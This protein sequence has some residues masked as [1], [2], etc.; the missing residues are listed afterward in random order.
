MESSRRAVESYWRWRLIDSATSDEDKVTPVYKLEEICELL[1]SSHPNIVKELSEFILKRFDNKSPIVKHKA[2]RLIKYAV[3]KCGAEFRRE[4]QRHSVAIR[5]LLHYKGQLDPMKG[6]A[7]NK[8]VRDT[9]QEAIAAIFSSDENNKPPSSAPAAADLNRRIQGFGNTNFQAPPQGKKSFLSEVV[10]LGSATI[11]Q[12]LSAFTQGHSSL[13]KNEAGTGNY[14]GPN[15][16]SSFN[17]E[18][19]QRGDRYEPVAYRRETQ[20]ASGLSRNQSGGPWN[21]DTGP[22]RIEISNGK[23]DASYVESKTREDRLMETVASSGGVRLQPTREAIQVFLTEA[24]KLDAMALCHAIERKLQSPMW[25]VRVKAVCVL[26]SILR[27]KDDDHFSCMASYFTENKDLVLRCSESPQASLRE[28]ANKVLGLLG[29]S[30]LNG[31]INSEKAVKTDSAAV[32]ELPNLID[33]G[34]L[35]DYHGTGDTIKST[36]DQNVANLTSS[37]PPTLADDLFVNF[38]SGVASNELKND[39]DPFADVS[40]HS[41]DNK[42]HV[43]IF[44]RM[45]VGDHKLGHHVSH[46]LGNRSKPETESTDNFASNSRHGNNGEFVDDLFAGL[47]IDENT[48]STKPKATSP[49]MQSESLFSGLSNHVSHLGPDN[50]LGSMLGSQAVGINVNS[51][52]P[53]GHPPYTTQPGVMLNQPYSSQPHNYGALGNLLAQ[54]Q[55]LAT[56]ANF[57]H[58]NN[59]NKHDGSTDQ[60][61]ER[62]G[63]TPLPDIFQSKF[64]AQTPSSMVNSSK[65]EETKAFDF[66]SDHLATGYDSRRMI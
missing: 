38:N 66:I 19:E 41:N 47:S 61:A 24:A 10:D 40:F 59:V 64:S 14:D 37:T 2:L 56:M 39:D 63:R 35:N 49:A 54:Q 6:D 1:R 30:Q 52:F 15:L 29:G 11:K 8:A 12:G 48:S 16:H 57:Q 20:T 27:K 34:D 65:K 31:A 36:N 3:G 45:T 44:S 23:T 9:A 53:P 32:A 7:L 62:N 58:L 51:I 17:A 13:I 28:K 55:F 60:N 22:T 33:T 50:G 5:Q 26:E 18:T 25:Q 43:D 46:G 21:Q 42:E 4:M